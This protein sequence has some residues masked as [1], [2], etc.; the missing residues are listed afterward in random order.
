MN[1]YL[2]VLLE[3]IVLNI[4][5]ILVVDSLNQIEWS[6]VNCFKRS[7]TCIY[8]FLHANEIKVHVCTSTTCIQRSLSFN[9]TYMYM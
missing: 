7:C 9:L 2:L 8:I 3:Q 4:L 1:F 5:T 6:I